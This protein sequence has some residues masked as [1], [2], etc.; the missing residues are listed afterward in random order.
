MSILENNYLI[1]KFIKTSIFSLVQHYSMKNSNE[2]ATIIEID[3]DLTGKNT[4]FIKIT[5]KILET[6]RTINFVSY[7]I[8]NSL[9]QK[10]YTD[11][12]II[13]FLLNKIV[14][15]NNIL[16]IID[17]RTNPT[18]AYPLINISYYYIPESSYVETLGY[19]LL[20]VSNISDILRQIL[21]IENVPQGGLVTIP[22]M[23]QHPD[24]YNEQN[25]VT[26]LFS[27]NIKL[28]NLV[29]FEKFLYD[30]KVE[31]KNV[32]TNPSVQLSTPSSSGRRN[33]PTPN[34]SATG[35]S[36]PNASVAPGQ[37]STPSIPIQ[38]STSNNNNGNN[39]NNGND[40]DIKITKTISALGVNED[41]NK[42]F[43]KYFILHYT[44][45][46]YCK[47]IN[48]YLQIN[49]IKNIMNLSAIPDYINYVFGKNN[50]SGDAPIFNLL[51]HQ[52]VQVTN[53]LGSLNSTTI[54]EYITKINNGFSEIGT[55]SVYSDNTL[56]DFFTVYR[57]TSMMLLVGSSIDSPDK[58]LSPMGPMNILTKGSIIYN[59]S[60]M[61]TTFSK[62]ND[63]LDWIDNNTILYKIY[64][65]KSD[66]GYMLINNFSFFK[67]QFECILNKGT[68][69]II[70]NIEYYEIKNTPYNTTIIPIY[71]LLLRS[72]SEIQEY[73]KIGTKAKKQRYVNS[74]VKLFTNH[75]E[76]DKNYKSYKITFNGNQRTFNKNEN[77]NETFTVSTTNKYNLIGGTSNVMD[78][79]EINKYYVNPD[80]S[81][82]KFSTYLSENGKDGVDD[83]G[84]LYLININSYNTKLDNITELKEEQHFSNNNNN[85]ILFNTDNTNY[86][87]KNATEIMT[88][89]IKL[90]EVLLPYFG[91][92][93]L[94]E[95]PTPT[96]YGTRK[97]VHIKELDGGKQKAVII[98]KIGENLTIETPQGDTKSQELQVSKRKGQTTN[99]YN[100]DKYYKQK[101]LKYKQK[102]LSLKNN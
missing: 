2:G 35:S 18:I 75:I 98:K 52:D 26:N 82:I 91:K 22:P 97:E 13:L 17:T 77:E 71:T 6:E 43:D 25:I 8:N 15:N 62:N 20:D 9:I 88:E 92:S 83:G 44:L 101:Y 87:T 95:T 37:L 90:E 48:I 31:I 40:D 11:S 7:D 94:I 16:Y 34:A 49:H 1:Y 4:I 53:L 96:I 78:D 100:I 58:T 65:E 5:R 12:G 66:G 42:D 74:F 38:P 102:Y 99:K 45:G 67:N 24:T 69:F 33:T 47:C 23:T 41:V 10:I 60:F 14:I 93:D 36:T 68:Y 61:S 89:I 46:Y 30:D 79:S 81:T 59:P 56:N 39:G 86:K 51:S 70:L 76:I 50:Q 28:E 29:N 57:I 64:I 73:C 32:S 72:E 19:K 63:L 21:I 3:G 85:Y 84:N 80:K 55:E 54:N 27:D